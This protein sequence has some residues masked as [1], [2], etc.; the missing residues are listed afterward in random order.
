MAP[1]P[2]LPASSRGAQPRL[3][4]ARSSV[5]AGG[6]L[7]ARRGPGPVQRDVN[8]GALCLYRR[9]RRPKVKPG[10]PAA[11]RHPARGAARKAA[12]LPFLLD[13]RR[14]RLL[15]LHLSWP[16]SPPDA[17]LVPRTDAMAEPRRAAR[18]RNPVSNTLS[19]AAPAA[20]A[21]AL[22]QTRERLTSE[23]G[24][25]ALPPPPAAPSSV[26]RWAGSPGSS[27]RP[28]PRSAPGRAAAGRKGARRAGRSLPGS[29]RLPAASPGLRSPRAAPTLAPRPVRRQQPL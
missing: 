27:P 7:G 24:A 3:R 19:F 9:P 25:R 4:G 20:A 12:S 29:A 6:A 18:A 1:R 26:C 2:P 22:P 11:P 13:R 16:L 23:H 21:K 5:P 28:A 8:S 14:R 15:D 10:Q 17:L